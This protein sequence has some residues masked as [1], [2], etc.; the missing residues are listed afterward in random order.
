VKFREDLFFY[1]NNLKNHSTMKSLKNIPLSIRIKLVYVTVNANIGNIVLAI[2]CL[3]SF[4]HKMLN[5]CYYLVAVLSLVIEGTAWAQVPNKPSNTASAK[6]KE[7]PDVVQFGVGLDGDFRKG[8][9]TRNLLKAR[10]SL[11]YE[12]PKS[13]LGFSTS[14]RFAYGTFKGVLNEQELFV[15]FNT[16]LYAYQR[17]LYYLAFGIIEKSN[18]RKI[19]T[20]ALG[21]VGFGYR[22]FGDKNHPNSRIKL[23]VT[24][25][26]V[27]EATD[28][29]KKEDIKVIRSSTR[30]KFGAEIIKG[31][32]FFNNT[33]FI[34][35]AL[36]K[37]NFRWNA[38]TSFSVKASKKLTFNV[39][40][41]NSYESVV[42]DGIQNT[43]IALTFGVSFSDEF[44]RRRPA[45]DRPYDW[46]MK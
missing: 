9:V 22:I 27:Y 23:T 17:K 41:D 43:D 45:S 28:Y 35:P 11:N 38:I 34:Q 46:W 2:R 8:N 10:L 36:N 39:L 26:I 13:I 5:I 4:L 29:Y 21:G 33:T 25:A 42:P 31:K 15:D 16:T 19:N 30:V 24:N 20:R 18:L 37:N 1:G 3:Y 44:R 32:L 6:P 14:P 40:L 7:I 12:T